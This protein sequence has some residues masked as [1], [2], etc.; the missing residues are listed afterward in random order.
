MSKSKLAPTILAASIS[1]LSTSNASADTSQFRGVNWAD[2]RDNFQ[3]GVIYVAG[4]SSTDTNSSASTVADRVMGQ[5][6]SKLGA[7]SVRLPINEA[8]VSQY[9]ST[10]TGAIDTILTNG[11]VI[12]C[13]WSNAHGSKPADMTAYWNMWKTVIGKY[14]SNHSSR[15]S[16]Q[17]VN[18]LAA[19]TC[20]GRPRH[21]GHV[22]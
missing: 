17:R 11:S 15:S 16:T 18:R 2:P 1:C 19:A 21:N 8:T 6:V 4:L 22:L 10:Y 7:N 3:S 13:Y 14:G 12:L 20:A 9:W 5:F